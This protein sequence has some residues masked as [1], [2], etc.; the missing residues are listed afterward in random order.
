MKRMGL[1]I[2]RPSP[3]I[4]ILVITILFT[5]LVF[6]ILLPDPLFDDPRSTVVY[7]K[8]GNLMGARIAEDGQW[9]FPPSD[10]LPH[11]YT[12]ALIN[13][14]DRYFKT[15][16]GINIPSLAR[17][18]YQNIREGKIV[19]GGSTITMQV[20]RMARKNRRRTMWQKLIESLLAVRF[21]LTSTK[22]EIVIEYASNAPF[23]G[24]V[25]GLEAASW[26]YF[27]TDPFNLS[28]AESALLAV[29]PNAPSLIHPGR[30]RDLLEQKRNKL[31]EMLYE[32]GYLD[33]L[34]R[35]LA[36]AEPLPS[37]P[38]PLP[39]MASHL[40]DHFLIS[41]PGKRHNSTISSE[42]QLRAEELA[43]FHRQRLEQNQ[44][45]NLACLVMEVETGHVLAYIGNSTATE[46]NIHENHVDVVRAHRST[47]SILKPILFS[48]MLDQGH[49]LESTLV[50]DVPLQ[51]D[52][53]SPKNFNR[54]HEGAVPAYQ[55]LERSLNV[56]SVAMLKMFGVDP[57]LNLLENL[58]FTTFPYS[59]EHYGLSLILGGGETSL[60]ELAGVYSSMAR[61][62]NHYN[63]SDGNYFISDL[64]MPEI[65]PSSRAIGAPLEQGV[66]SAGSIFSAFES[67]L[68]V[69][70]PEELSLWYLMNSSS[71]IAWKTGTSYGFRDAWAIGITPEFLVAVWAGNAD[72]EGR[73]GLT[74]LLAA[75]PI[76]FDLFDLLP[77]TTWFGEPA[78]EFEYAITCVESGHLAGPHCT[79]TDSSKILT[80]GTNTKVCPYHAPV[81]LTADGRFRVN[82]S[83]ASLA[84]MKTE[85]WFILPPLME[86][87]Y[88]RK[89]P[90]YRE[91]PPLMEGCEDNIHA[92]MEIVYPRQGSLVVIPVELDG[93]KGRL[94]MEV[95]HRRPETNIYWHLEDLYLGSTN[96]YH[97]MAVDLEP[98]EH[99]LTVVDQR[100]N[101]ESIQFRVLDSKTNE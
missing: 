83:C 78:D 24:N 49:L 82:S 36:I 7:D 96:Q 16:P 35:T 27:G 76:M 59:H 88:K 56:P 44:V 2:D 38:L 47:G 74:G 39:N 54:E 64:R 25:V 70:R 77:G 71:P 99:K 33:S 30:N 61:I 84:E 90:S 48:G 20:M 50:P 73:P 66:I 4:L 63:N 22:E 81:H 68:K 28:W 51:F 65:T 32:R 43:I 87:Y 100:G 91:L 34:T 58:G 95:A 93:T 6:W 9:R 55:A 17:A 37:R 18:F 86:W 57:F 53:Y 26:R 45:H 10:S 14:E 8:E 80:S 41:G 69:N 101:N 62:L 67:M 97:R 1:L 85:S 72:G 75:A 46:E 40:T 89:D 21:E 3:R 23:G 92:D 31:L 52:G 12:Q 11:K 98:G 60:W 15:H 19:S 79:E 13:Y 29:L 5:A 42:L 94:V